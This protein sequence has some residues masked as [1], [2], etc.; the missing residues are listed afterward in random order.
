MNDDRGMSSLLRFDAGVPSTDIER[1]LGDLAE[2]LL[3]YFLRRV[4]VREDAADCVA[5]TL[6]VVWRRRDDL[7]S[8]PTERMPWCFGVAHHVLST[9]YRSQSRRNALAERL[10][11]ALADE[12]TPGADAA[13][14][15]ERDEALARSLRSLKDVDRELI[16]LVVW[17]GF[18]IADAAAI[19]GL[20]PDAA[21][22]RYGRA[23]AKLCRQLGASEA[24]PRVVVS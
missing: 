19:V 23:W 7:P 17:E 2:P 13:E 14:S 3:K 10:R 21:R 8:D 5:E 15:I 18:T 11:H 9:H 20:R 6:L 4:Q 24:S 16:G 1:L 12:R 22:A